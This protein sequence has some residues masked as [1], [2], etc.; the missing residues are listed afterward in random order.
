ML[1]ATPSGITLAPEGGAH[2]SRVTTLIGMGQ[3]GLASYEPA[4]VDELAVLMRHGF[5]W[6]QRE[7]GGS[8]YLRLSTRPVEQPQRS[9]AAAD[10]AAMIDGAYWLVPP[11]PGADLAVVYQGAIAPEA[12]EAHRQL[13]EDMPGVGLLAVTSAER[14]HAGWRKAQSARRA[15]DAGAEAPVER[16]LAALPRGAGLVTVLDGDPA[17]LTWLGAVQAHRVQSLGIDRFGQSGDV[18]DLY[19]YYGLDADAIVDAAAA[20]CLGR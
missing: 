19:R 3:S 16:L 11:G 12:I 1:V 9:L 14:L 15:G 13:R 17:T 7:D 20:L 5:D 10:R 6:M 4:F 2:Q 18:P 8:V